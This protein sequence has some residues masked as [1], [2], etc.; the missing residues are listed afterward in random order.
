M[1]GSDRARDRFPVNRKPAATRGKHTKNRTRN[2]N[3]AMTHRRISTAPPASEAP[4][5]TPD[6]RLALVRDY[7]L[8][9]LVERLDDALATLVEIEAPSGLR[10][11]LRSV[12]SVIEQAVEF[13][14]ETREQQI[15]TRD[16]QTA[17][18]DA[19]P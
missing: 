9:A 2:A 4:N 10:R 11:D 12:A 6:D 14:V 8:R 13:L 15:R 19:A 5:G 3:R 16:G 18:T 7:H 17:K 1:T